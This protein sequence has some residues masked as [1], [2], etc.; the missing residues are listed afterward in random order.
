[1]AAGASLAANF[2]PFAIKVFVNQVGTHAPF[3]RQTP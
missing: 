2:S 1:M 3:T